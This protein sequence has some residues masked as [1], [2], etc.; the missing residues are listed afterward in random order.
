MTRSEIIATLGIDGWPARGTTGQQV[1]DDLAWR[2]GWVSLRNRAIAHMRANPPVVAQ[3]VN[4][5]NVR[6]GAVNFQAGTFPVHVDIGVRPV[7]FPA[8]TQRLLH[9]LQ[10]ELE[11]TR[12]N[13]DWRLAPLSL[14]NAWA[15][16]DNLRPVEVQIWGD[17]VTAGDRVVFSFRTMQ[18]M[19]GGWIPGTLS[20][21]EVNI[22]SNS[23]TVPTRTLTASTNIPVSVVEGEGPLRVRVNSQIIRW[24]SPAGLRVQVVER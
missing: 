19:S 14:T 17:V 6:L 23:I 10:Q 4:P 12:R 13:G 18:V 20:A 8:E 11:A 7:S 1:T 9:G 24:G 22:G 21:P 5:V 16:G 2:N 15:A 3:V